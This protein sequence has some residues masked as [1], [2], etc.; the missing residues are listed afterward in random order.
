MSTI[1]VANTDQRAAEN[2][3]FE[4]ENID[5][6]PGQIGSKIVEFTTTQE[7]QGFIDYIGVSNSSIEY[8]KGKGIN[9]EVIKRT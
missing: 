9:V 5:R 8:L 2:A 3:M 6:V 4:F 1:R 7:K